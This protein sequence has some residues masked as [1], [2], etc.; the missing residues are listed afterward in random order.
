MDP[1]RAVGKCRRFF[2]MLITRSSTAH[3]DVEFTHEMAVF[4]GRG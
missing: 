2:E 4:F 3:A 1:D